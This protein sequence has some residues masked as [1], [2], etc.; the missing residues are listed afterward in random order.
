MELSGSLRLD[1]NLV[2]RLEERRELLGLMVSSIS[3]GMLSPS[4]SPFAEVRL[5]DDR[6]AMLGGGLGWVDFCQGRSEV[7]LLYS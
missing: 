2:E 7:S 4:P 5:R 6:R 1:E 3:T